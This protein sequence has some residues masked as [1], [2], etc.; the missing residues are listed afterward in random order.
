[1]GSP[2][3]AGRDNLTHHP[4]PSTMLYCQARSG[5]R[6]VARPASTRQ[7]GGN[8]QTAPALSGADSSTQRE[9]TQRRLAII[10]RDT[11]FVRRL[12]SLF[13]SQ[14]W[15]ICADDSDHD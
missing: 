4:P 6:F 12:R 3:F 13:R 15:E 11:V 14:A 5:S 2:P 9:S 8:M 1:M 7:G 10:D